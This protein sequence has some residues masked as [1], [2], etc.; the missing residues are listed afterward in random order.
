MIYINFRT[1]KPVICLVEDTTMPKPVLTDMMKNSIP[2]D[3][4]FEVMATR[5]QPELSINTYE[6]AGM[7]FISLSLL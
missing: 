5:L 6:S 7:F 4:M 2:I 1:S 3:L